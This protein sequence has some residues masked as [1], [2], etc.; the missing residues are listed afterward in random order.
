MKLLQN[1]HCRDNWVN[2]AI[3]RN[4]RER[5]ITYKGITLMDLIVFPLVTGSLAITLFFVIEWMR[6]IK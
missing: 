1:K 2:R 4:H 3:E 5:T 6:I